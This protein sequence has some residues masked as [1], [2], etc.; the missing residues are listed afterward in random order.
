MK[1][2]MD[3]DFLLSNDVAKSCIMTT[4]RACPSTITTATSPRA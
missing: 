3:K 2:F 4:P 1:E